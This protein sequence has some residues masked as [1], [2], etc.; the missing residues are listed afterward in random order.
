MVSL[1]FLLG[2]LRD[3]EDSVIK[4]TQELV[5]IPSVNPPGD[6]GEI[7]GFLSDYFDDLGFSYEKI[8]PK[9]GAI[10]LYLKCG[11]TEDDDFLHINGHIDV[12][13]PGERDR[14]SRDPF[15]GDIVDGYLYG[16]GSSDMKS[17]TA[18]AIKVFEILAR[19][20]ED[21]PR[22]LG[23]SIVPDEETGSRYSIMYMVG[24][25]G[26]RP[27][28]V[29]IGEP[30]T[31]Y[32][33]EVGEKG[34]YQYTLRIRG[35]PAHASLSPYVGDNAILKAYR[36]LEE[37]YGLTSLV[38]EP[39]NELREIVEISGDIVASYFNNPDMKRLYKS[40]TCNV[41]VIRGG[42]KVNVVAPWAE[43]EMDMRLPLGTS[44][45]DIRRLISKRLDKYRDDYE[46]IREE[47]HDPTF[48]NPNSNLVRC[49]LEAGEEILGSKPDL[50]LVAGATDCRHFRDVGSEAII[51]GPG[52]PTRIHSYDEMVRVED[53]RVCSRIWLSTIY[54]L[55]VREKI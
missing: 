53:I 14:W 9:R 38:F 23:L 39:P 11:A 15:S 31:I 10:T 25:M 50:H 36:I 4:L 19:Y 48:T 16:R 17:G 44:I 47:G 6:V 20:W 27:R 41:G 26:F 21:M 33:V 22:R 30:S 43:L 1:D 34:I 13:P 29:L 52:D 8:E 35:V 24:E 42:D 2:K 54:K 37:L 28:Y 40:I 12:V 55:F 3:E 45:D 7:V 46:V 18:V 5:K 32:R 49:L 51:Y